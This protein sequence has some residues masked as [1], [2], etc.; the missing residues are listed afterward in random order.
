MNLSDCDVSTIPVPLTLYLIEH[1]SL[2]PMTIKSHVPMTVV[3]GFLKPDQ[4]LDLAEGSRIYVDISGKEPTDRQPNAGAAG[5]QFLGPMRRD[6]RGYPWIPEIRSFDASICMIAVDTNVLVY[7]VDKRNP[8]RKA[9]AQV[10]ISK[11]GG[12]E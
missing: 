6:E 12:E 10:L 3:G 8:G 7:S 4:P 9:I 2:Y 5:T 11:L 1:R